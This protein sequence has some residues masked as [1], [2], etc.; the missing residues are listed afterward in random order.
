MLWCVLRSLLFFTLYI[1]SEG[2]KA[3]NPDA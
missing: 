1:Q 2:Y 3:G